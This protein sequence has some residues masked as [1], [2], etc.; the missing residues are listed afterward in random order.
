MGILSYHLALHGVQTEELP[1]QERSI[2]FALLGTW[3][4]FKRI[5]VLWVSTQESD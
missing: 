4:A 2:I 3:G 5:F 1:C